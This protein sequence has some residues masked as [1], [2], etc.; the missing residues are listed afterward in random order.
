MVTKSITYTDFL[1]T[2]RTEEFQ[3]H[4]S[5][6]EIMDLQITTDGG[7]DKVIEKIIN[8]KDTP[9]LV[10]LFKELI[11]V[12]YG[13]ITQDGRQFEKSE[14]LKKAFSQSAAFNKMYVDMLTDD[15]DAADFVKAIIPNLDA[16]KEK[17]EAKA[18]KNAENK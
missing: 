4:L 17:L 13:R 9:G 10:S 8:S 15:E 3:F 6:S 1:G 2:E 5:E 16:L 12:S 14:E 11:L 7:I 18:A